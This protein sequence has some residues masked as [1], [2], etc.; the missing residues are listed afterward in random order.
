MPKYFYIFV[1][2]DVPLE[3]Q[4]IQSN[5]ATLEMS[6]MYEGND[7]SYIVLIGVPGESELHDVIHLLEDS[8]IQHA[9]FT[10]NDFDFK[11][12]AVVTVPLEEDQRALLK[13]Y[14]LWRNPE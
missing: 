7:I 13:S 11:M 5:H 8:A 9:A 3:Q 6:A 1:R 10:D 12:A 14:H 2:Q 4:I